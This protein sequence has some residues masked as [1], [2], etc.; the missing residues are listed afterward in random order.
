MNRVYFQETVD[1]TA[2]S[3]AGCHSLVNEIMVEMLIM[4]LLVILILFK[5]LFS[6]CSATESTRQGQ[7]NSLLK[8]IMMS[9]MLLCEDDDDESDDDGN[10]DD[11]STNCRKCVNASSSLEKLNRHSLQQQQKRGRTSNLFDLFIRSIEGIGKLKL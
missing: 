10:D 7:G 3:F 9:I 11:G 1:Q 4:L 5:E 8:T 2:F 6:H